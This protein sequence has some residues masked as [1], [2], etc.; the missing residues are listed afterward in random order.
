MSPVADPRRGSSL[1]ASFGD[2]SRMQ[3]RSQRSFSKD[4]PFL[5]T[6]RGASILSDRRVADSRMIPFALEGST[7]LADASE[8]SVGEPLATSTIL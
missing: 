3:Q 6:V 4:P 2:P 5:P 7:L 1:G 8:A